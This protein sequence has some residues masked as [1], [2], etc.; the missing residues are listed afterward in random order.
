VG[1]VR[2]VH[3]AQPHVQLDEILPV[4]HL[5]EEVLPPTL[6]PLG[7]RREHAMFIEQAG[8]LRDALLQASLGSQSGHEAW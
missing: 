1:D 7:H 3:A 6:L 4:L 2:T 5:L 8:N